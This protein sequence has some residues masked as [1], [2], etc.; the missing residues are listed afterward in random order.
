MIPQLPIY[1]RIDRLTGRSEAHGDDSVAA[2]AAPLG[3]PGVLEPEP[4]AEPMQLPADR[5]LG[6]RFLK[7]T[8]GRHRRLWLG[9]A[10]VGLAAG[11][12][13]HL[14]VPVKYSA[15]STVYLVH[16]STA[17]G[18][19]AAQDDLA[20]LQ[21]NAVA[22]RALTLLHEP[23]LTA[24][25]LLG[26]QPGTL[27]SQ[28]VLEIT[29]SGP[30]PEIA[31]RRVDAL[32]SAYLTFRAQ[33]FDQQSRTLVTATT[34]QVAKLQSD[35]TALSAEIG[36]ASSSS[37]E[38]TVLEAQRTADLSQITGLKAAIQDDNLN[39][40]AVTKGSKVLGRGALVPFSRKKV[41]ILDGLTGLVAGLG[42]GVLLVVT[43]AM[44]SDRVRRREDLA[45]ILGAPV[46][47]S[48]GRIGRRA[49]RGRRS[50]TTPAT[51]R[52]PEL[53][54]FVRHLRQQLRSS[55]MSTVLLVPIGD[56]HRAAAAALVALSCDLAGEGADVVLVDATNRRVLARSL[57]RESARLQSLA[58][59][60]KTKPPS[61]VLAPLPRDPAGS[62]GE[63]PGIPNPELGNTVLVLATVD[64]TVGASHLLCWSRQAILTVSAG[65]SGVQQVAA[66]A[67]LLDAAGIAVRSA[68]LLDTDPRDE[69]VGL[70]S[71]NA[72]RAV[73][74]GALHLP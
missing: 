24:T 4:D 73:S 56:A 61:L 22:K 21:T 33:Q 54:A 59:R 44:L 26:K 1:P 23:G 27:L 5:M 42:L 57:H 38:R 10:A 25:G 65:R 35:V 62:G 50:A 46:G 16:A 34:A 43:F 30:S 9:A 20:I 47:A 55:G 60:T 17:S 64:P 52:D 12:L 67:E 71:Q 40:L 3:S 74:F 28:N 69:S 66:A 15:A 39:R 51:R 8:L 18:T 7:T 70:P 45:A 41:F 53:Q 13:Y 68:V 11:G 48:I 2:A 32:T 58:E 72:K 19:V 6:L 49:L 31:V 37:G 63:L 36:S 14:A 29:V